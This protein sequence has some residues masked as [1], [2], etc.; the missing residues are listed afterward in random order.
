MP[1]FCPAWPPGV[2]RST[3]SS[4][5]HPQIR[6]TTSGEIRDS[7]SDFSQWAPAAAFLARSSHRKKDRP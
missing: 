7:V 5:S 3:V 6:Q 2:I 4:E 1:Q